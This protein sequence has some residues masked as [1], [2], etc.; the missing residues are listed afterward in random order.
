MKFLKTKKNTRTQGFTRSVK[1]LDAHPVSVL[2]TSRVSTAG[3]TLIELIV[4]IFIIGLISGLVAFNYGKFR[5]DVTVESLAQDIALTI[6]RAQV[7]SVGTKGTDSIFPS[8]GIHFNIPGSIAV[9]GTEKDIVFFADVPPFGVRLANGEYDNG[10]STTD[11]PTLTVSYGDECM[12]VINIKSTDKITALC[13][14]NGT[15]CSTNASLDIVFTRPNTEAQFCY[16]TGGTCTSP[17]DVTIKVESLK[18][19]IKYINVWNSGQ[20]NVK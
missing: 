6:R 9:T 10:T 5:S 3:F 20:I 8:Y 13:T 18:G 2:R 11:C 16:K 4:V 12:E 15:N 17:T 1:T 14:D 7:Y 19:S